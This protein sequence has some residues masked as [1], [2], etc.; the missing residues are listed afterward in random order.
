MI[1][2]SDNSASRVASGELARQILEENHFVPDKAEISIMVNTADNEEECVQAAVDADP[3]V[4]VYRT[5]SSG[6]LDPASEDG[7]SSAVFDRVIEERHTAG[8]KTILISA[9]LP[10]DAARFPEADAILLTYG[11]SIMRELP[12]ASGPDS[13]YMPNLPAAICACFGMGEAGGQV[14]VKIPEL[15]ENYHL[16][17]P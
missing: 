9:Q 11:S 8:K 15:D 4:L 16:I 12:P 17:M 3:L 13:G 2:F 1:L 6:C 14:P 10:Y 7:F 5:Y